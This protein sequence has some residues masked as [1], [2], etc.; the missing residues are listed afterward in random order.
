MVDHRQINKVAGNLRLL[1]QRKKLTQ[2]ALSRISGV[3]QQVISHYESGR[4]AIGVANLARLARALECSPHDIDDRSW[5]A[6]GEPGSDET[7]VRIIKD[8]MLLFVVDS[9]ESLPVEKKIDLLGAVKGAVNA[10]KIQK[11]REDIS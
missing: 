7:R 1:R 3:P 10:A 4:N 2:M 9:W 6:G 8:D 5:G 11:I